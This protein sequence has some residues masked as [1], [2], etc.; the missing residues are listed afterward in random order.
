MGKSKKLDLTPGK[1]GMGHGIRK[2]KKKTQRPTKKSGGIFGNGN[3]KKS[4]VRKA[5]SEVN[6]NNSVINT[7]KKKQEVKDSE[8]DGLCEYEKIRLA[9]IRERE[10]MFAQLAIT[11]AKEEATPNRI[12]K[13]PSHPHSVKKEAKKENLEPERK[14]ARLSG[15]KVPEI[16][17]FSYIDFEE[18]EDLISRTRRTLPRTDY[19]TV[20]SRTFSGATERPDGLVS[21][22][23]DRFKILEVPRKCTIKEFVLSNGLAFKVGRG[24]YEFSKPEIISHRKEVVLIEKSSGK[25]FTGHDACRMIGAGSGIR[26]PPTTFNTWRVFVQ[27]TSY[28]RNLVANTGFLYE[29]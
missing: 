10:A 28:G 15:G 21:V 8:M 26:I 13:K 16:Q 5:L 23:G 2:V 29:A 9:N 4:K 17:R 14:S 25:M 20:T 18:S 1:G 6:G 24:F 3:V 19:L 7:P 22:E 27:S 12:Q 11:E